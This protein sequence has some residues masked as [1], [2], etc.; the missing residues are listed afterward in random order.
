MMMRSTTAGE[1][2]ASRRLPGGRGTK[3]GTAVVVGREDGRSP[4]SRLTRSKRSVKG[5]EVIVSDEA[6]ICGVSGFGDGH[7]PMTRRWTASVIDGHRPHPGRGQI[8]LHPVVNSPECGLADV[9]QLPNLPILTV[10]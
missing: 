8:L 6:T 3:A 9:T 1:T 2:P 4:R 5:S 10:C 7:R